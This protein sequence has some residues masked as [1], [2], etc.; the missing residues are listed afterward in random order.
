M[1]IYIILIYIIYIYVYI[2][3]ENIEL[4]FQHKEMLYF[5]CK[6]EVFQ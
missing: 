2:H 3:T 1:Y 5:T 4:F 6:N